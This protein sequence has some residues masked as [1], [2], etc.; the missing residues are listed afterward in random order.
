[1]KER[2]MNFQFP[3]TQP[4]GFAGELSPDGTTIAGV[5]NSAQGG[6]RLTFRKR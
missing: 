2:Q 4:W 1:M 6:V 5:T 3:N